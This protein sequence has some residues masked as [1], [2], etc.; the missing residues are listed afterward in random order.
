MIKRRMIIMSIK[1]INVMKKEMKNQSINDEEKN[2]MKKR[3]ILINEYDINSNIDINDNIM[4][5]KWKQ[6][7]DIDID[8][9]G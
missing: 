1:I 4:T 5:I 6:W 2:E 7:N 9:N 8:D 3:K